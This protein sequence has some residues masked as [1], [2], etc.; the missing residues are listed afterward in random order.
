M[1]HHIPAARLGWTKL[2]VR[3]ISEGISKGRLRHAYG[4]GALTTERAYVWRLVTRRVPRL[5]V[6]GLVGRDQRSLRGAAAILLA[7]GL[8]GAS[9]FGG[10]M[11]ARHGGKA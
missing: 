3:C 1:R 9:C 11:L 2:A 8:T 6:R 7:L 5:L 10:E 4:A